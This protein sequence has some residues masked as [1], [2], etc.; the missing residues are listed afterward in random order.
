MEEREGGREKEEDKD[1]RV[2]RRERRQCGEVSFNLAVSPLK[3]PI[4]YR[5]S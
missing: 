1:N 2:G 4:I 5:F 3:P